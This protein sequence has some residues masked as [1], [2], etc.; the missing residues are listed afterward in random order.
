V[1]QLYG[2]FV[3]H[4]VKNVHIM[5]SVS[6]KVVVASSVGCMHLIHTFVVTQPAT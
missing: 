4:R 2:L 6:V 3:D 1:K 5:L